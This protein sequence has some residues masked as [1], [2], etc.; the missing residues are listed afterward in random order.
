MN[1]VSRPQ[2]VPPPPVSD[3][4]LHF[5]APREPRYRAHAHLHI[6]LADS[7]AAPYDPHLVDIALAAVEDDL[8]H[9]TAQQR[10]ALSVGGAR[11][12]PALWQAARQADDVATERLGMWAGDAGQ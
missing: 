7:A 8:L 5:I 2:E 9:E 10:L 6:D 4:G 3:Y 1:V 11:I 12:S